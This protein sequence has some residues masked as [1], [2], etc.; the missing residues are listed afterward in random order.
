MKRS[1][2]IFAL[3]SLVVASTVAMA[4]NGSGPGADPSQPLD[5]SGI[6][7]TV[8]GGA[9]SGLP[10]LTVD[11]ANLGPIDVALGPVWFLQAAEFSVAE[12]D[13]VQILAYTCPTCA[14]SV[15]AAW[16]DNMTNGTTIDL[17]N[18]DGRPLW[19]QRQSQRNGSTRPGQGG[20]SGG[21]NGGG[22][23]GGSGSGGEPGGSG[24]SGEPGGSAGN[25]EPG[26]SGNGTGSGPG[27]GSGLDLS[28]IET[29]TGQ[30]VDFTGHAGSGQ[31][32]LTIDGDDDTYEITVSPYQPIVTAG[33]VIE[34]G[35]ILTVTFA[36]TDCDEDPHNVSI[37]IL[38][39]ATGVLIQLRDP[40]TGFPVTGSGGG[41]NRP[42]WP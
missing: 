7:L 42:N 20:G 18:E 39:A 27:S 25:G 30:V 26:G 6:V 38:D 33:L 16:V 21:T 11:D 2:L 29:V 37:S 36:P 41:H 34:P 4:G 8:S 9:G 17:R 19:I 15:V 3:L 40:E 12:G 13:T 14:A 22:Q 10:M 35:M 28:Q 24:G 1:T 31:P 32:V 23:G 5:I